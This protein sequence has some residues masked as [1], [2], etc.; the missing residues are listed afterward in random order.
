MYS[1][2]TFSALNSAL[3]SVMKLLFLTASKTTPVFLEGD[4]VMTAPVFPIFPC[5][6]LY[7]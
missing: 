6:C 5:L 7:H 4:P 1:L 2:V 3:N